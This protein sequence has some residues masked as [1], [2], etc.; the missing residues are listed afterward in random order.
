M[1]YDH[2]ALPAHLPDL[3]HLSNEELQALRQ[4][5]VVSAR[6]ARKKAQTLIQKYPSLRSEWMK[7]ISTKVGDPD[8]DAILQRMEKELLRY[9]EAFIAHAYV[10]SLLVLDAGLQEVLTQRNLAKTP[11]KKGAVSAVSLPP[12]APTPPPVAPTDSAPSEEPS[13][14]ELIEED[15]ARSTPT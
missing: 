13:I 3:T 11:K 15:A 14:L 5:V 1:G 2:I 10:N 12:V 7:A 4:R 6:D 8:R 9:P